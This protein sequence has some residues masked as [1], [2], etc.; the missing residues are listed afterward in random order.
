MHITKITPLTRVAR[1]TLA[2]GQIIG[3]VFQ[4]TSATFLLTPLCLYQYSPYA[5]NLVCL[6]HINQPHYLPAND[7]RQQPDLTIH[8]HP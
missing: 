2:H 1:T 8:A 7:W 4:N 5:D 3:I 6:Q